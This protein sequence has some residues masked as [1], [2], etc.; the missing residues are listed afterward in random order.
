VA[1]TPVQSVPSMWQQ[2]SDQMSTVGRGLSFPGR[3]G[4]GNK[5]QQTHRHT[6]THRHTHTHTHTPRGPSN[7]FARTKSKW[8]IKNYT[9]Q[10]TRPQFSSR[11]IFLSPWGVAEGRGERVKGRASKGK[12]PA[13]RGHRQMLRVPQPVAVWIS[14]AGAG[15]S[16]QGLPAPSP[17]SPVPGRPCSGLSA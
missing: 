8:K 9:R 1:A 14:T 15:P 11:L 2:P 6:Y 3:V 5:E 10:R 7:P 4:S 16:S 13:R 12:R 17:S